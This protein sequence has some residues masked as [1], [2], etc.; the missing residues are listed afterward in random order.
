MTERGSSVLLVHRSPVIVEGLTN[1]LRSAGLPDVRGA[2]DLASATDALRRRAAQVTVCGSDLDGSGVGQLVSTLLDSGSASVVVLAP[3]ITEQELLAALEA[4]ALGY[5]SRQESL[6]RLAYD[7]VGATRG[8][9]CLPRDMLAP[10]LRLLIDRRRVADEE[11]E[12]L[13]R[14]S[15]RELEVLG[16]LTEGAG[17][18]QIA[19]RLFLST[20]TVRTHVQ[21]ILRKL[22]VH[23][24]LEAIAFAHAAGAS[25]GQPSRMQED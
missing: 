2:G 12:R 18:D 23:S 4:G 1:R 22:D 13:R 8:E 21:N 11:S 25:L 15:G 5:V 6:D 14:L 16:L 10:V 19:A 9:A 3:E 7:I 24:R 20:A 17:N